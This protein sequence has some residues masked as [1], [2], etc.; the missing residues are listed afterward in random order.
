MGKAGISTSISLKERSGQFRFTMYFKILTHTFFN[1][2]SDSSF[3]ATLNHAVHWSK[4]TFQSFAPS[5][6]FSLSCLMLTRNT[7][8]HSE[9]Y[10]SPGS[11]MNAESDNLNHVHA[12]RKI[13]H[14][15][16]GRLKKKKVT[17]VLIMS[18]AANPTFSYWI[19][20]YIFTKPLS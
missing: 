6:P 7:V 14:L 20:Y 1:S 12:E 16:N 4:M 2:S 3:H 9:N 17:P 5:V 8:R 13:I 19:K 11:H 10:L 15:G 18:V